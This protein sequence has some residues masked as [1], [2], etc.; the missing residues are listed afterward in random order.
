MEEEK[1]HLVKTCAP[2]VQAPSPVA[3]RACAAVRRCGVREYEMRTPSLRLDRKCAACAA[4]YEVLQ[5]E[6]SVNSSA[7]APCAAGRYDHDH[8][9]STACVVCARGFVVGG[10]PP[11]TMCTLDDPCVA[12][13]D[14][15][16]AQAACNRT[17]SGQ[18][19]C[20]CT[21]GFW[22]NG[23]WCAPWTACV[24]GVAREARAPNSTSGP[25]SACTH[26]EPEVASKQCNAIAFAKIVQ[27][28]VEY[29]PT[30][31]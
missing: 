26:L 19:A 27:M 18:H 11:R 4:G 6:T 24:L 9:A 5:P 25:F 28:I 14:E 12:R 23:R 29:S 22:G 20:E 17:E 8:D 1:S 31:H 13:T 15:C 2:P 30:S 3:D 21:E 7:C 16:A 10:S